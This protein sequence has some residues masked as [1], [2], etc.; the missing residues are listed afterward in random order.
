VFLTSDD[1]FDRISPTNVSRVFVTQKIRQL[2]DANIP[3]FIIGGNHDVP[4]FGVSLVM[5]LLSWEKTRHSL[6]KHLLVSAS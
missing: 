1:V 2:K 4:K 6:Y 3:V 5:N